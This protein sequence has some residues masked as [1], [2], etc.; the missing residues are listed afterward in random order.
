MPYHTD[1]AVVFRALGDRQR[2]FNWLLTNLEC[3]ALGHS[4]LPPALLPSNG[5]PVWL[6]GEELTALVMPAEIQFVWGVLTGFPPGVALNPDHADVYPFADGN[7]AL[8]QSGG[9]RIQHPQAVVEIVCW[10]AGATLL[11]S[12]DDDISRRFRSYFPEAIDLDA[13]IAALANDHSISRPG[14]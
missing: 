12:H 6:S 8:W 13:Y 9:V 4:T 3:W 11:L 2:E 14:V 1:L 5:G 10:D 7:S